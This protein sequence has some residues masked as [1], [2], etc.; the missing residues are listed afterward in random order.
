MPSGP[1]VRTV[2]GCTSRMISSTCGAPAAS[3]GVCMSTSTGPSRNR[4]SSTPRTSRLRRI[5]IVRTSAMRS[6]GQRSSS[7]EPPSP[8]VAVTSTTRFPACAADGH[9]VRT[10]GRCRRRGA[11]TPRGSCRAP[12]WSLSTAPT[13]GSSSRDLMRCSSAE[14]TVVARALRADHD[15]HVSSELRAL[16]AGV[17]VG[18]VH[19]DLLLHRDVELTVEERLDLHGASPC[20]WARSQASSSSTSPRSFA[21]SHNAFW[22]AFLPRCNR[23]ITV[24]I[25][26]SMISAISL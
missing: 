2:S 10:R 19:L 13:G 3:S 14:G 17:A 12:A 15:L 5:S 16:H 20:T 18:Q 8:R 22:S 7:I 26:V 6:D 4:C 24:P 25:G 23:D 9:R 1:K 11:P 21:V